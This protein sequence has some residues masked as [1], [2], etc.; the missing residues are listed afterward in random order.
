MSTPTYCGASASNSS[1]NKIQGLAECALG[2]NKFT[3]T[4]MTVM[5]DIP[6]EYI[7]HCL[8]TSADVFIQQFWSLFEHKVWCSLTGVAR[9]TLMLMKFRPNS[10]PSALAIIVLPVPGAPNNNI[11]DACFS[12]KLENNLGYCK[13]RNP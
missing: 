8:F 5:K 3:L 12:L 10:L 13:N 2:Y 4:N 7:S 9:V 6:D 11:P 1:K